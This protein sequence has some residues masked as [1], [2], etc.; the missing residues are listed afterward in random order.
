VKDIRPSGRDVG[1]HHKHILNLLAQRFYNPQ[2]I[3]PIQNFSGAEYIN[4]IISILISIGIILC[5]TAFIILLIIGGIQY[6][7]SGGDKPK[8]E[9]ARNKIVNAVTGI[10]ILLLLWFI[11][12]F[13]NLIFGT[14]I[15]DIGIPGFGRF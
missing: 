14:N 13:F 10:I 3:E 15:G 5:V 1:V 2:I 4:R 9:G 6:M 7:T 11:L 8:L 12:Q